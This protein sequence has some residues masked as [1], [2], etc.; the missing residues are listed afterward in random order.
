M[1]IH[2]SMVVVAMAGVIVGC[3]TA[4]VELI[5]G[6]SA[7]VASGNYSQEIAELSTRSDEVS[8]SQLLWTLD[9]AMSYSLLGQYDESNRFFDRAEDILQEND[10]TSSTYK[11]ANQTAAF[12]S[13]DFALD[14][15]C[16]G[17]ERT[18]CNIYKAQNYAAQGK[19]AAA[20][21]ELNRACTRQEAWLDKC[22]D[23]ITAEQKKIDADVKNYDESN[24][25]SEF[26]TAY[27][28]VL[29]NDSLKGDLFSTYG[30]DPTKND[31][32][33]LLAERDF[34]NPYLC[35]LTGVMKRIT[36]SEGGNM[37]LK[38]AARLLP[39]NPVVAADHTDAESGVYP[40]NK[41]WVY[42][43]DGMCAE[44]SEVR[45]AFPK[46]IPLLKHY[47]KNAFFHLPKLTPSSA[48][49]VEYSIA[50]SDLV[51]ITDVD[52]ML[53]SDFKVRLNGIVAREVAK[54]VSQITLQVAA[55]AARDVAV[56][57]AAV[58]AVKGKKSSAKT[59][60]IVALGS[61]L[62]NVGMKAYNYSTQS[63]DIRSWNSLP[64]R[65]LVARLDRPAD[66]KVVITA[67][68]ERLEVPV[69]SNN[70]IVWV[71][72]PSNTAPA[73]VKTFFAN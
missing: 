7:S 63:V 33:N 13:D 48:D 2:Y 62:V 54:R 72:K 64:K 45:I 46:R 3:R 65:V 8:Q 60:A 27:S 11:G 18:F 6:H 31:D 17:T 49:D 25:K 66:G 20:N 67:G 1:K 14:Y 40:K 42:I 71:R 61:E 50:G 16:G 36:M 51:E 68:V 56:G 30:F 59:A 5:K 12:L 38:D 23:R 29:A 52:A 41:V 47:A 34:M 35:H 39:A 57:V 21:V 73:V 22:K 32:T 44:L 26:S 37:H 24:K 43:E 58:N 9:T 69:G 53:L 28:E 55:G 70:S 10:M 19:T 15:D 4:D